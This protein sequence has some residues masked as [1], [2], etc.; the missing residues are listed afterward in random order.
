MHTPPKPARSQ[1]SI[2]TPITEGHSER[3]RF[4]AAVEEPAQPPAPASPFIPFLALIPVLLLAATLPAQEKVP[5]PPSQVPAYDVVSIKPDKSGFGGTSIRIDD[6]NYDATN[7]SL[8][9]FILNA[10]R[11]KQ[12]Q[13]ISLPSWAESA[14]FD[15]QAKVI[16]PDK[17]LLERLS[18]DQYA[19]MQ[20][21]ILTDRFQFKF[22]MESKILPIY[23][24]VLVKDGAKFKPAAKPDAGDSLNTHNRSL[25]ATSV[26]MSSFADWLS[27]QMQ[28]IVVDKTGLTGKFDLDL[29][30]SPDDGPPPADDAPPPLLT[31]LQE[32]LGLR[33]VS[34]KQSVP[35][36]IV[37]NLQPPT[38]N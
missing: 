38:E 24:L 33:L 17:K 11:L 37:E 26:P 9:N 16:E 27:G 1:R 7:V 31:A 2:T 35:V 21:P 14:R 36:L 18:E 15:I 5:V 19:S 10:Y 6:G 28:R 12:D 29:K 20:R 8:K 25:T 30:W 34:S 13:L 22:H 32:H 4:S 3:R 23:E